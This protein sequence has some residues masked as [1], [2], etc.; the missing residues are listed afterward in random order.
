[1]TT[2]TANYLDAIAHLPS[3]GTLILTEVPWAE[4]EQLLAELGEGYAVRVSYDQGRL[5]IMTPS[6]KHEKYKELILR[7]AD[8]AA[9][10]LGCDLD[11]FGSTTFKREQLAKGAEPDTCFYVQH[12]A[13]VTGKDRIDLGIDPPPD[14][15]VEIDVAHDST[16][17]LAIYASLGVPELWRYDERRL[18]IYHLTDREYVEAPGSRAFPVLTS[19]VLSRFLERSKTEPQRAVLKSFREWLR[20]QK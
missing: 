17:K 3:G 2:P 20:T 10:E 7:L 9:D 13:S 15:V 4:Y 5:E 11:S 12:A 6:A 14:V 19:D 1:M 18:Q 16:G 8:L